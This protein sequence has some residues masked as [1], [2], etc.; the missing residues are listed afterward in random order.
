MD[1]SD[2]GKTNRKWTSSEKYRHNFDRIFRRNSKVAKYTMCADDGKP[3]VNCEEPQENQVAEFDSLAETWTFLEEHGSH[4][5]H[6][7]FWAWL[8]DLVDIEQDLK[9]KYEME[10]I[11]KRK[12]KRRP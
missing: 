3:K 12:S 9:K 5:E 8:E 11:S 10:N 6:D 2:K 7:D 4:A 1:I